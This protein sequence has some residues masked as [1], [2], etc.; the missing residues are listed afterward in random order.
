[1]ENELSNHL[2][3]VIIF[4]MVLC[5]SMSSYCIHYFLYQELRISNGGSICSKQ[6]RQFFLCVKFFFSSSQLL[7]VAQP[8]VAPDAIQPPRILGMP[9]S[10]SNQLSLINQ[11]GASLEGLWRTNS[12][13]FPRPTPSTSII[14][15]DT[16][17]GNQANL[18]PVLHLFLYS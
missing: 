15:H 14:L 9:L 12:N 11:A 4:F 3:L 1:M 16:R 10:Q 17:Q 6:E 2:I 13:Q 7:Y 8:A 18:P 5:I